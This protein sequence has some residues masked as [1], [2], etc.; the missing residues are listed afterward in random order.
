MVSGQRGGYWL[1]QGHSVPGR[2]RTEQVLLR[3]AKR[4]GIVSFW[5]RKFQCKWAE[6]VSKNHV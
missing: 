4:E 1:G 3:L 6:T 5:I 2:M